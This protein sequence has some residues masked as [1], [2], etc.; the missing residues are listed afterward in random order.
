MEIGILMFVIF[1]TRHYYGELSS[2]LTAR[3]SPLLF[4][5]LQ[6]AAQYQEMGSNE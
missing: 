6:R 1:E 3:R 5:V 4:G 2:K